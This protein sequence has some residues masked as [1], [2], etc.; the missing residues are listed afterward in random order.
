M[1]NRTRWFPPS[2]WWVG[3]QGGGPEDNPPQIDAPLRT[4]ST[5]SA[6]SHLLLGPAYLM[7]RPK[8]H[9]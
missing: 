3:L 2:A 1:P 7:Q 6:H 9:F 8:P 4:L 5:S